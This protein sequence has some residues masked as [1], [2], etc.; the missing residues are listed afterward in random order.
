MPG[1]ARTRSNP[2]GMRVLGFDQ[3]ATTWLRRPLAS[4]AS[5]R[6]LGEHLERELRGLAAVVHDLELVDAPG[7][8]DHLVVAPSGIWLIEQIE[9]TARVA[10]TSR[11]DRNGA[12]ETRTSFTLDGQEAGSLIDRTGSLAA[13]R[14][15]ISLMDF[16]VDI[17][18]ATCLVDASWSMSARPINADGHVVT[19]PRALTDAIQAS[20]LLPIRTAHDI[21]KSV[22]AGCERGIVSTM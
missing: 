2:F 6:N 20:G 10:R 18:T 11:A 22:S 8:V 1:S 19:W 12:G 5:D 14:S 21:A 4:R 9:T 3:T 17:H 16:G 7:V 15:T 13:A